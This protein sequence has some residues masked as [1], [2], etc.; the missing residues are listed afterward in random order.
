M[1]GITRSV[2]VKALK[3]L[4]AD[5]LHPIL[6]HRHSAKHK[7]N[8]SWGK[9]LQNTVSNMLASGEFTVPTY[10]TWMI[11][12]FGVFSRSPSADTL[13]AEVAL[14]NKKMW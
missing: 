9:G 14:H 5:S 12:K 13:R 4:A 3:Q 8:I 11:T 1:P 10:C 7:E 2:L 6:L